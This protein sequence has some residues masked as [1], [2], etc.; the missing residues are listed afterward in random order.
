MK[1][2]PKH[3]RP[4]WRYLGV[5]I[6]SWM[7][8]TLDRADF[9]QAL[10]YAAGNLLGDPGSAD[11]GLSVYGFDHDTARGSGAAVV[12][13]RRGYVSSARAALA[14]V[15]RVS[16]EPVGL[17]VRGVSGTVQACRERYCPQLEA[18]TG[19]TRQ[20]RYLGRAGET[21]TQRDVA[22]DESDQHATIRGDACDV[23]TADDSV[24]ATRL[25]IE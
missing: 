17:R 24:G 6:E 12:R 19:E 21:V 15:T 18:A 3:L 13:V 14:C 11:A 2:L 4:R 16:D 23:D 1:H 25:D 22:F 8:T 5:E 9:Q 20:Q 10:R 7:G